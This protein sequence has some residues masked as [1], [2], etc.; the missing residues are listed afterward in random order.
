MHAFGF[1]LPKQ[2]EAMAS[3]SYQIYPQTLIIL[4]T[5]QNMR[6]IRDQLQNVL[7]LHDNL[8]FLP[9]IFI[10]QHADPMTNSRFVGRFV[11]WYCGSEPVA[12]FHIRSI[13]FTC[14]DNHH[15]CK[16]KMEKVVEENVRNG[17]AAMWNSFYPL[18]TGTTEVIPHANPFNR[19]APSTLT[20]LLLRVSY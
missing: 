6:K 19:H 16:A 15:E 2:S 9:Q 17:S 8:Y 14:S 18:S 1:V 4:V 3:R 12:D 13:E 20:T 7:R 10:L 5:G 11:C